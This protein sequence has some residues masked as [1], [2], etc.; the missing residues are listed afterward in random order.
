MSLWGD[1]HIVS[2]P[3]NAFWKLLLIP[4]YLVILIVLAPI[5]FVL[6]VI[7]EI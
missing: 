4:V 5:V 7:S 2:K 3:V 1:D 6:W